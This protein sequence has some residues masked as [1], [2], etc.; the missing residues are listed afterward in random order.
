[1]SIQSQ[2][3]EVMLK[4]LPP[5]GSALRVLD[6]GDVSGG[7]LAQ[8]RA[9]LQI[10]VA[11]LYSPHWGYA[12]DS[13]D[14]VVAYDWYLGNDFLGAVLR[15]MRAGGRLIVVQPL[16][17]VQAK[18][19]AT[20]EAAGYIRIL[21][22]PAYQGKGLLLRGE[23]AHT[24][25]DTLARVQ[26]VA[27]SDANLLDL[28]KFRGRYVHLLIRQTPNKPVWKLAPDEKIEWRAAAIE[29]EDTTYLL[30]FSSLPKSVSFMQPAVLQGIVQD[31]NKVGKFSKQTAQT[32]ILPVLLNPTLESVQADKI[33]WL[34]VDPD[35]AEAPDE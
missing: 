1:M 6:V 22:E 30:A 29:R 33:V 13:M 16:G 8:Y 31:V 24:T 10:E 25:A 11:S 28:D 32:W 20:L 17:T 2:L 14:A 35:T 7:V 12:P 21:V 5:S 18:H 3:I 4:H 26:G 27:D 34:D 9:D 15:V 23:K 19:V